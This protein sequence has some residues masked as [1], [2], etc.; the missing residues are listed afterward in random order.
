MI[1]VSAA[2]IDEA[3]LGNYLERHFERLAADDGAEAVVPVDDC[4]GWSPFVYADDCV[5]VDATAEKRFV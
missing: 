1:A 4:K 2:D 3:G 5:R